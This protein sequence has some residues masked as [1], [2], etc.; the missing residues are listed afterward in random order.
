MDPELTLYFKFRALSKSIKE[1]IDGK[2]TVLFHRNAQ[3]VP[4]LMLAEFFARF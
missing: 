3:D 1:K 2:L 4:V